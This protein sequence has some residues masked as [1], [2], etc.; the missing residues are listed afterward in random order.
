MI[1]GFVVL[2]FIS[3]RE[4]GVLAEFIPG[5]RQPAVSNLFGALERQA[6]CLSRPI[7]D[8]SS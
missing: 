8:G 6:G 2:D 4:C 7:E 1:Q 3:V 5:G